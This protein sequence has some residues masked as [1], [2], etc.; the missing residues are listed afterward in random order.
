MQSIVLRKDLNNDGYEIIAGERYWRASKIAN[1]DSGA[2][3]L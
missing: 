3:L 1:P 2:S